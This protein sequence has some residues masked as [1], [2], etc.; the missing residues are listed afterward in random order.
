MVVFLSYFSI[1]I[2]FLFVK[3][4]EIF[5]LL[6]FIVIFEQLWAKI[7]GRFF[8]GRIILPVYFF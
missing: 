3:F 5:D 8:L 1:I 4:M 6:N 7:T 2:L